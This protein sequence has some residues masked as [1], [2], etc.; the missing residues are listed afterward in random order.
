MPSQTLLK[1]YVQNYMS[2]FVLSKLLKNQGSNFSKLITL[3][4]LFKLTQYQCILP[5]Q[6]F[7]AEYLWQTFRRIRVLVLPLPLVLRYHSCPVLFF[8][9]FHSSLQD[10]K[11][12][13]IH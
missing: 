9:P 5:G 10:L 8:L 6:L 1:Y 3:K 2:T 4:T 7:L 12:F 11:V 13:E